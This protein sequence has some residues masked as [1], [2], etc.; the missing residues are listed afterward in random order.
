MR[1]REEEELEEFQKGDISCT[2]LELG[3]LASSHV[4]PALNCA[5]MWKFAICLMMDKLVSK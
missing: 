3:C 2:V 4:T 5:A 1:E